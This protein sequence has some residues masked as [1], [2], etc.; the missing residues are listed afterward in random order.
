M[1]KTLLSIA[2]TL[3]SFLAFSQ[4]AELGNHAELTFTPRLDLN[5]T[6]NSGDGWGF[7]HGNS[8]I[9]TLFEGSASEH[10]SWTVANL[11]LASGGDYAWPYKGLTYSDT[12]NWLNYFKADLNFGNWTFTLG[13]DM[14]S[15]GGFEFE[16]WD[17]DVHPIAASPFWNDFSAY[18]W[19]AMAAYTNN[20]ENT[21]F[22]AQ[23]T[24]SPFGERPF[25]SK[26]YSYSLQWRG[27]YGWFSNIWSVSGIESNDDDDL[28]I[29]AGTVAGNKRI[30]WLF[31]LGQRAYFGDFY[32][33][34]D[35]SNS[36]GYVNDLKVP[37]SDELFSFGGNNFQLG[38]TYAPADSW[39][40]SLKANYTNN[41]N[42][43]KPVLQDFSGLSI[44][45]GIF[46]YYPF[47]DDTLRL[48]AVLA[49]SPVME[50]CT[51]SIGARYNFSL[52]LW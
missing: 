3:L 20:A 47:T 17:W 44:V 48:H 28:T 41:W 13:K 36:P 22:S 31:Y 10:F 39:N 32:A 4:E 12:T 46:E 52:K 43:Y 40:V 49:Y 18:Q 19:G 50:G 24:T 8:S 21:T 7:N 16:D 5:P 26:L 23:I 9:Y 2:A 11:W 33:T 37:Y 38:L 34:L 6:Y 1:K 27:E 35:W 14:I 30:N 29:G 15:T 42:K 45:A 25:A 51:F